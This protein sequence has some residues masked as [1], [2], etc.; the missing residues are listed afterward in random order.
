MSSWTET[1]DERHY[2]LLREINADLLAEAVA[3][4]NAIVNRCLDV[5]FNAVEDD[6]YA[7]R[8]D[9]RLCSRIEPLRAVIRKAGGERN[10]P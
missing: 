3:A 4:L 9:D 2:R 8:K 5:H 1:P 10:E 7:C 6:E